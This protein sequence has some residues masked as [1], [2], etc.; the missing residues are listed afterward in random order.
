[1]IE[2]N[3]RKGEARHAGQQVAGLLTSDTDGASNGIGRGR[4]DRKGKC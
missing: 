1:M 4:K 2:E 3:T